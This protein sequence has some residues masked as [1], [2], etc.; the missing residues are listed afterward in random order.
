[1]Q[2]DIID[3]IEPTPKLKTKKCKT[4]SFLIRIFLQFSIYPITLIVWWMYDYFIAA[5]ALVL[6]YVIVG[7]IRAKLRNGA[8][9][10]KQQE[11]QYTDKAIADWYTA[12]ELCFEPKD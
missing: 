10:L 6:S 3:F 5:I 1:M 11:Y 9:P 8:I 12:R 2:A 4:I 7:I